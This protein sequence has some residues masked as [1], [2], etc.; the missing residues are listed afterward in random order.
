[1][2]VCTDAKDPYGPVKFRN[3]A[4]RHAERLLSEAKSLKPG[5]NPGDDE[6]AQ[7]IKEI[8]ADLRKLVGESE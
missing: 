2:K 4:I 3:V 7:A 5:V 6:A 8:S 1:L